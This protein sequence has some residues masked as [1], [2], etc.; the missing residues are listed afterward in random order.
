MRSVLKSTNVWYVALVFGM[1]S[2][3]LVFGMYSKAFFESACMEQLPSD[4]VY[5]YFRNT[6]L[7]KCAKKY[8]SVAN[9]NRSVHC[10]RPRCKFVIREDFTVLFFVWL[11]L[12][13]SS[14]VEY[15]P[16]YTFV[17]SVNVWLWWSFFNFVFAGIISFCCCS[18]D[19]ACSDDIITLFLVS[20]FFVDF[21]QMLLGNRILNGLTTLQEI[22]LSSFVI[23]IMTCFVV[24][25]LPLLRALYVRRNL[26]LL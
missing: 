25:N 11:H 23:F 2:K 1:Y 17:Y 3:A 26:L 10:F 18:Y 9:Q 21:V 4:L 6:D 20:L 7:R 24:E 5:S 16:Q 14:L 19:Y 12:F 22:V 13:L 15:H 8:F